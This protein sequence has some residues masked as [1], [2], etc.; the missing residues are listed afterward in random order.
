MVGRDNPKKVS[1][2]TYKRHRKDR[3]KVSSYAEFLGRADRGNNSERLSL[4]GSE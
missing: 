2:A 3:L 4:S 1:W